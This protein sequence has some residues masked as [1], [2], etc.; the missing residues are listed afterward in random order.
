MLQ[1]QPL[2][3][4]AG[5]GMCWNTSVDLSA[6]PAVAHAELEKARQHLAEQAKAIGTEKHR[7]DSTVR[8]YNAAHGIVPRVIEPVVLE[9]LRIFGRAVGKE[10]AGSEHPVASGHVP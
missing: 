8:E 3:G 9:K 7:L 4:L 2:R 5:R 10:L 1:L 6:D